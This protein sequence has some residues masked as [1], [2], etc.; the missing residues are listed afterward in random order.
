MAKRRF[1]LHLRKFIVADVQ[2]KYRVADHPYRIK[3]T[4][5]SKVQ[6]II[7]QPDNLP[8]FSYNA[9]RLRS[10]RHVQSTIIL[11]GIHFTAHVI[12]CLYYLC[13]SVIYYCF[14][15]F[16]YSVFISPLLG[17]H[18]S[19]HARLNYTLP[20]RYTDL[21]LFFPQQAVRY[22]LHHQTN[23]FQLLETEMKHCRCCFSLLFSFSFLL[24]ALNSL[25]ILPLEFLTAIGLE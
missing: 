9:T 6:E 2:N 1:S 12:E 5:C 10:C 21:T 3:I 25:L 13:Y 7:P 24:E 11:S 14:F 4:Q 16:F 17:I 8:L 15:L 18:F 19:A 20:L 22:H 23:L